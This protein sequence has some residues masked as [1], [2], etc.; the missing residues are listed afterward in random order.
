MVQQ[1]Y[2]VVQV[3][4]WKRPVGRK[5]EQVSI[6]LVERHADSIVDVASDQG[7]L[8]SVSVLRRA[9]QPTRDK[10]PG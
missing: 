6:Q 7:R 8:E 2:P 3:A 10:V 1:R 5:G 4:S 9:M